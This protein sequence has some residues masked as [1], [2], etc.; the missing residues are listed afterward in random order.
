[1]RVSEEIRI[2]DLLARREGEFLRVAECEAAITELL[3]GEAYPFPHPGVELPSNGRTSRNK[4][5]KPAGLALPVAGGR[6]APAKA[7]AREAIADAPP[8]VRALDASRGENAYRVVYRDKSGAEAEAA[9][10][11]KVSYHTDT[12]ALAAMLELSC[13]GFSIERIESVAFESL[14]NYRVIECLWTRASG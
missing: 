11:L 14:E 7:G 12:A 4:A 5:W 1:M 2:I 8:L 6:R 3:G 10:A 13:E 9:D